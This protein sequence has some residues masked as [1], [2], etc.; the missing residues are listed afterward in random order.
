MK[1]SIAMRNTRRMGKREVVTVWL[2]A[3][4]ETISP[5]FFQ[6]FCQAEEKK[7]NI[8]TFCSRTRIQHMAKKYI[9][10]TKTS[11]IEL[12]TFELLSFQCLPSLWLCPI[13]EIST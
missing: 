9:L 12:R 7:V 5:L 13:V 2:E 3:K 10:R 11:I 6:A 4:H 1:K 8:F